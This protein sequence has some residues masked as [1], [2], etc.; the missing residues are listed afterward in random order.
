[1]N[2]SVIIPIKDER[3]NLR[4][5]HDRLRQALTPLG[6]AYELVFVDDGSIDGSFT[7]LEELAARDPA[8]K[9]VRLRRNFG[10]S[11]AMQAGI[12]WSSGDVVVTMDGDLQ[13]DPADIPLL[14]DKLAEGH[15]AVFGLRAN[16]QDNF[17]IRKLPSVL[18]NWLIRK[19]TG[20]EVRDMGC[21]LRA[22]R[23]E[24]AEGLPLYGEMHRFIPVLVQQQGARWIQIPVR[25]HPRTAGKTKYNLSRTVRVL[26]DLITVK[27]MHSYVTRPMHVMGL[28]GL[29]SMGLGV[30][31]LLLT[32]AMKWTSG[33]WMTGNPFLHLSALLEVIGI[34]FISLGLL[35]E[36]VT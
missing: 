31:S 30:L 2:L 32:I 17:L 29:T 9:V 35:A 25:H 36:L 23:R 15:D 8:V 33:I 26:L 3:D 5:L 22:M 24:L 7:V 34:Q 11:A 4:P 12:D 14:L 10:Q 16:R 20:V 6:H 27:F 18:A 21:T 28:A 1:M 13:N 19:V